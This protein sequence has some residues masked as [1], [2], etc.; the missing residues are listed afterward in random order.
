MHASALAD[1]EVSVHAFVEVDGSCWGRRDRTLLTACGDAAGRDGDAGACW[2]GGIYISCEEEVVRTR[3]V[4]VCRT[5]EALP[6]RGVELRCREGFGG[7]S[8]V[9]VELC[10][11]AASLSKEGGKVNVLYAQRA[12]V[13]RDGDGE[14]HQRD[15]LSTPHQAGI[16]DRLGLDL[17]DVQR[18]GALRADLDIPAIIAGLAGEGY[19][20]RAVG[21]S[22]D[23]LGVVAFVA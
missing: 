8:G 18:D 10:P 12:L 17:R 22:G 4:V 16:L 23:E 6:T 5:R 2:S 14:L 20:H 15:V 7:L 3:L 21:C 13:S 9:E 1:G 19:C 11:S